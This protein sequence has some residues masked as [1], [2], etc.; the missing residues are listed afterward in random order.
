MPIK[1]RNTANPA[2]SMAFLVDVNIMHGIIAGTGATVTYDIA[3]SQPMVIIV[4]IHLADKK[5]VWTFDIREY[6]D[7]MKT[8]R[9]IARLYMEW[10]QRALDA[11]DELLLKVRGVA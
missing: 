9:P 3:M 4:T 5:A 11:Y 2:E 8:D 7:A 1:P 6:Q 10:E